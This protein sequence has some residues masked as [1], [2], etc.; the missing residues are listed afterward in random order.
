M[1]TCYTIITKNK[2]RK[3]KMYQTAICVVLLVVF[4]VAVAVGAL[5][6]MF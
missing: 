6:Q 4:G 1:L 2:G 5:A 3:K